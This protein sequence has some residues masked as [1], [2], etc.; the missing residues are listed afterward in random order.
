VTAWQ[1]IAAAGILAALLLGL[2]ALGQPQIA[3]GI[4]FFL[5][6]VVFLVVL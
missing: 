4:L 3:V 5:A 2:V 6:L 1:I